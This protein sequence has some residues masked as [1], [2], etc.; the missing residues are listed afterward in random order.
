LEHSRI[1]VFENA[2]DAQVY[3]GSA[4]LMPR[5]LDRRV[6]LVFPVEEPDLRGRLLDILDLMWRD[7][8]GAWELG[9]DAVYK[10]VEQKNGRLCAQQELSRLAAVAYEQKK[11]ELEHI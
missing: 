6:E 3:L 2:G 1:F 7:N 4:D 9:P 5:N 11:K 10:K 8:V